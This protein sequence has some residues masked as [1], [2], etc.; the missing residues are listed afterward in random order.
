MSSGHC[1]VEAKHTASAITL[2]RPSTGERAHWTRKSP[3]TH[4]LTRMISNV[5]ALAMAPV[6]APALAPALAP[7]QP[8]PLV[9]AA[10]LVL[11]V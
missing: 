8:Q 5:P 11:A 7:Q 9:R 4:L 10:R 1:R 3:P 6:L 2:S